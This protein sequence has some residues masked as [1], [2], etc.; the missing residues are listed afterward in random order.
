MAMEDTNDTPTVDVQVFDGLGDTEMG[1]ATGAVT[2]TAIA[3]YTVTIAN[4]N[5]GGPPTG[6]FNISLV[7][8]SARQQTICIYTPHGLSTPAI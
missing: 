6:F 4:A 7:P 2:G 8:G 1:G 3:E 5:I